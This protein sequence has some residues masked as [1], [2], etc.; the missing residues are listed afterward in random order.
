MI[1]KSKIFFRDDAF[2]T[3]I[4]NVTNIGLQ[5][6]FGCRGDLT[7]T[8]HPELGVLLFPLSPLRCKGSMHKKPE[9]VIS[10]IALKG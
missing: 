3:S 8:S 4:D 6:F 1:E 5:M 2:E 7:G 9:K 10:D